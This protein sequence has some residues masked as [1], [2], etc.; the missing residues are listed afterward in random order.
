[1]TASLETSFLQ[2]VPC[3]NYLVQFHR[4]QAGEVRALIDFGSKV[5]VITPIFTPK[6]GLFIHSTGTGAQKILSSALKTYDIAITGISIQDKSDRTRFFE[7]TFLLAD[8]S[9]EIVLGILFLAL[10]NAD[11]QFDIKSLTYRSY[12]AAEAL[13]I[14]RRVKII[15]KHK[16]A[17]AIFDNKSG[18][19]VMYI[20]AMKAL[21]P[22]IYQSWAPLLVTLKQDKALTEILLEY[23]DYANVFFPDLAMTLPEN[24]SI[25]EYAIKLVKDKQPP[26]SPIYT[27]GQVELETTKAYIKTHLKTRFI[28]PSKFLI[29]APIFFEKKPD[30][31]LCFYV[32]YRGLNN[33]TIKN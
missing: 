22:A 21:K 6:L 14:A 3:I 23:V 26:Y 27:L 5:N 25:K 7:E 9:I 12:N 28:W 29:G 30:S 19:F 17:Q 2:H 4:G 10:S 8:T 32:D 18:T 24:T 33:L 13:P 15:N 1:M 11:I 16:S 20:A 31:S